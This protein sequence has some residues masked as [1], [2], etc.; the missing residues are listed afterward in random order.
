MK[1]LSYGE[2]SWMSTHIAKGLQQLGL[3]VTPR[4]LEREL[5]GLD[6]TVLR[7]ASDFTPP[8]P[9]AAGLAELRSQR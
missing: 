4:A 9:Y 3:D 2:R 7:A 1:A 5:E 6:A 8:D